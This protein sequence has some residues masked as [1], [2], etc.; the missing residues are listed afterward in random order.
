MSGDYFGKFRGTVVQNVD[1]QQMGRIQAIVPSATNVIPT[2]WAMPCVPFT[3]RQS[4]VFVVPA[5]GSAVWI[6]YEQGDL[7][8]PI[9]TGGF[10][11]SAAEVPTIALA[12]NPLS[13][14][15]VL[16]SGL[17]NSITISDLPGPAGGIQI[18]SAGGA[19]ILVNETGITITNGAATIV[20]AGPTVTINN[21][22][23]AVT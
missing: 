11:G 9:W 14:S 3:G 8:Y 13:P 4:G 21:G 22:A 15:I 16:Q 10:W 6:E 5:I 19:A 7:D 23:L 1:P 12:G 17:G 20:L 18:K 2:T